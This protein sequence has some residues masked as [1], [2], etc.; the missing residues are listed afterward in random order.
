VF[1]NLRFGVSQNFHFLTPR[2]QLATFCNFGLGFFGFRISDFEF[3]TDMEV[4]LAKSTSNTFDY[5]LKAA[6]QDRREGRRSACRL[7]GQCRPVQNPQLAAAWPATMLDISCGGFQLLLSRRFEPG[8]LLVVD[9]RD[10]AGQARM[11]VARVVRVA[12]LTRGRWVHGC[13]F[14][15]PLTAEDLDSLLPAGAGSSQP[16]RKAS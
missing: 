7:E 10:R 5:L 8:T 15:V 9:V 11:L 16:T 2:T 1:L 4:N 3:C 14:S 13:A 6:A 12:L